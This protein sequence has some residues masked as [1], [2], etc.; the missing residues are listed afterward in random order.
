VLRRFQNQWAK[1]LL[2]L[3]RD[4]CTSYQFVSNANVTDMELGSPVT[5]RLSRLTMGGQCSESAKYSCRS[6]VEMWE[7]KLNCSQGNAG[8]AKWETIA[9]ANHQPRRRRAA[10]QRRQTCKIRD[11]GSRWCTRSIWFS[12]S[13]AIN[14]I[15]LC[16][17]NN[18][19]KSLRRFAAKQGEAERCAA[20]GERAIARYL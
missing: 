2:R 13:P 6:W 14:R 20:P 7:S 9:A 3:G 1:I 18:A 4:G 17:G 8:F 16:R 15:K 19:H 11:S 12:C 10:R 5:L